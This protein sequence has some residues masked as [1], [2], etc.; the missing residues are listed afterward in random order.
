MEEKKTRRWWRRQRRIWKK[1]KKKDAKAKKKQ[2]KAEEKRLDA[3]HAIVNRQRAEDKRERKKNRKR[4]ERQRRRDLWLAQGGLKGWLRL[5]YIHARRWLIRTGRRAWAKLKQLPKA[6]YRHWLCILLVVASIA[7]T[8]TVCTLSVDRLQDAFVDLKSSAIY[9]WQ[10][11]F[12]RVDEPSTEGLTINTLPEVDLQ[13]VCPFSIADLE[14]KLSNWIPSIFTKEYFVQYCYDTAVFLSDFALI[15]PSL[16]ILIIAIPILL[17]QL[18]FR[19]STD[20]KDTRSLVWWKKHMTPLLAAVKGWLCGFWTFI[21]EKGYGW[22]LVLIW[23]LNL[24]ALTVVVEFLAWYLHFAT[25]LDFTATSVS[26]VRLFIDLLI[27]LWS[28][29]WPFWVVFGYWLFDTIRR[30]IGYDVLRHNEAKNAGF[31]SI[32]AVAILIV[33]KMGLGKTTLLTALALTGQNFYRRK[34][35]DLMYKIEMSFP[36]FPFQRFEDAI[37]AAC[38][39]G[40][41]HKLRH[42][43]EFVRRKKKQFMLHKNS[44]A[45]YGYD[46]EYAKMS[47]DDALKVR[48]IFDALE[49][50]ACLYWLYNRRLPLI[51]GNYSVR[52]DAYVVEEGNFPH[53]NDDFFQKTPQESAEHQEFCHILDQDT[54]RLEKLM[55]PDNELRGSAD[56]GIRIE[57]EQGKERGNMLDHK[58]MK[59]DADT[60]NPLNDGRDNYVK[61]AR[62]SALIENTTFTKIMGDEQREESLGANAREIADIIRIR[63]KSDPKLAMP[64]YALGSLCYELF[65][66]KFK[67]LFDEYRKVCGT[68]TLFKYAMSN[69]IAFFENRHLRIMN[70][71]GYHQLTLEMASGKGDEQGEMFT[72]YIAYK[73]DYSDRFASD[74]LV[75]MYDARQKMT[76]KGIE[77][78][79]QFKA[80]RSTAKE[81]RKMNSYYMGPIIAAT[82]E[83]V[84]ELD[85]EEGED[86]DLP[87]DI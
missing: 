84:D 83:L 72:F 31:F 15:L 78:Y 48:D 7:A 3:E 64:G 26:I 62:H 87:S 51:I 28:A 55:N 35:R 75:G 54:M 47:F 14:R 74:G 25:G 43:K 60:A 21:K 66:G 30:D 61:T 19:H 45:L 22:K 50:Y 5:K 57:T 17:K 63:E 58:G 8:V 40:E 29:P 23:M 65:S 38:D 18:L 71:F 39:A 52:S 10:K 33:G 77:D 53:W 86:N 11:V 20:R 70:T 67:K 42:V 80:I 59:K 16:I 37:D 34:A 12:L 82:M 81:M 2:E 9:Y 68:Q 44:H 49:S 32:L 36:K 73:K 85:E 13:R 27:M 79:P 46:I 76:E 41:I 69:I 4:A 6:D 24:N 1:Q 56:I